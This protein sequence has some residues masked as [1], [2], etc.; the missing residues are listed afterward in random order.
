MTLQNIYYMMWRRKSTEEEACN[1]FS[2]GQENCLSL[3]Y[4]PFSGIYWCYS[5]FKQKKYS[6]KFKVHI[7]MHFVTIGANF[8]SWTQCTPQ[9]TMVRR[10]KILVMIRTPFYRTSKELQHYFL[11]IKS[12]WTCSSIDDRTRAP[13]FW[14]LTNRHRTSNLKSF[15]SIY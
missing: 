9:A 1:Y 8:W 11:N 7:L 4:W 5:V 6:S 14:L 3:L 13:E 10:L 12:T 15:H 2:L